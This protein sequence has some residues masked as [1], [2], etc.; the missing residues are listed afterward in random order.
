MKAEPLNRPLADLPEAC[1]VL[2]VGAGPAGSAAART[3]A[4]GGADVVLIDQ[5]AFPRD[6]V[7]GDGL[8]PDAHRALA[9]LGV[10]DEV[11][12]AAQPVRHVRCIG[13]RG[14]FVD[15]PGTLAVLP[16]RELDWIVCR[17]AAAAGAQMHAPA[18]FVGL[19]EESGRVV[20][21]RVQVGA[22]E[23]TAR[24]IRARWV[25]LATG[26]VPQATLAAGVCKRRT[27]S[28]IALRGYVKND[29]MVGRITELEVL[30]HQRLK[31][32][33]GW[34]FPCRDGLF[35][36]GVGVAHSHGRGR[37]GGH[38]MPEVNLREVFAA[39]TEVHP[40]ARELMAGGTLL[41]D[42]KGAPLRCSLE[43]AAYSMPGLL[44][45]GEAAGSTYALTGEGIGKALETGILAAEALLEGRW[46]E[47]DDA[48]VRARY[49]A[50][51]RALR[52]RFAI[53]E[54]ANS[55]N[56]RPWLV[57]L[58]VWSARRSPGRLK[59]MTGVLEETHTPGNLISARSF[60]KLLFER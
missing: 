2:V 23:G 25:L 48:T 6:K 33:Y 15:V 19:I 38:A 58:L 42:L 22:G 41:G 36:I 3:L 37:N 57:D 13:P 40:P 11:L 9:R 55:V 54:K 52:P 21:A 20:G 1:D 26:A 60:A 44:I 47:S 27:P 56:E 28:A 35:N 30:W 18:R 32:G 50:S 59:R 43:G 14:G 4:R 12:A 17:S 34:I 7:C 46:R 53:Y 29:A 49:E 51:L 45:A 39:F 24:E 31:P 16:R 5:H 10:L 8:I